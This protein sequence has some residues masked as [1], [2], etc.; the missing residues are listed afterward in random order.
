MK[1]SIT[2]LYPSKQIGGAQ[3][4][5][6]RLAEEL[7]KRKDLDVYLV[8]Y[9]DG[10]LFN[11]T[12][13]NPNIKRISF[14][15]NSCEIQQNTIIITPLSFLADLP[16][17][18]SNSLQTSKILF[19]CIHPMNL[20]D[21]LKLK[22]RGFFMSHKVKKILENLSD[23]G[24]I[25]YMD[26]PNFLASKEILSNIAITNY[27]PIPIIQRENLRFHLRKNLK[28]NSINLA[29]LGRISSD[30]YFSILRIIKELEDFK[31]QNYITFHIIGEGEKSKSLIKKISKS[32]TPITYVGKLEGDNLLKYLYEKIDLGVAMGTSSL[33]IA[34]LGIP[35]FLIDY[36][37]E[38]IT[39]PTKY[40]W[41]Y[42]TNNFN[43]GSHIKNSKRKWHFYEIIEQFKSD[44]SIGRKSQEYVQQHHNLS[45]IASKL[46][47][48][49]QFI[50]KINQTD[51][52]VL[53]S[54]LNPNWYKLLLKLYKKLK[55][56]RFMSMKENRKVL[57]IF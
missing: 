53:Q 3:L 40:D 33:E 27:L 22:F 9:K 14:L 26:E 37:L 4:L 18:V 52:E 38:E 49:A 47:A 24:M 15:N 34:S 16:Y 8:D 56:R 46:L 13:K 55:A 20:E 5:F 1:Y 11:K 6:V 7:S 43:L 29:W 50:P 42:E 25:Q 12:E 36:S 23:I 30:K 31:N 17:L 21:T 45:I 2:F 41:L 35:T 28:S 32:Q 19:W 10:F 54:Y 39:S 51:Y 48:K 57:Q 44:G